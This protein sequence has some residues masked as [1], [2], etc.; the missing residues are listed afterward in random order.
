MTLILKTHHHRGRS[1]A[2]SLISFAFVAMIF[3]VDCAYSQQGASHGDTYKNPILFADYSD[4]DVIRVGNDYY[5]IASSF[6]FM[7]G[8]PILKS[9][10]L[11][12]WTIISHVFPSLD[13][14]PAYALNGGNRYGRGAWAPAIRYHDKKF[15]V[16]FPT[17]D[18]GIFMS[19]APTAEGPWT[20]PI[21]VMAQAGLE[22]PCP[23]WDDDGTAYLIHSKTGA[24][25]LYLHKM[26]ADGTK[27][28]DEGK[29]IVQNK[30]LHTLEGPKLYKR[31]DY[32]YIFAPYGG[33]STGSQVVLR[34]K[35]IYGP[36]EFRT[37]LAQGSTAVNGPH[38]GGYIET[39]SGEGWFVHF[40]SQGAY[41]RI[42]YLE[43]VKWVDDWPIMGKPI[44]D[45]T[46]EPVLTWKKPDVGGSFP[47]QR[48]QTSDEFSG[49]KLGQQWEWNHNPDDAH[50]SLSVR[51]GFMRL[52]AMPASDLLH[53]RNTLTQMMQDPA[54]DLTARIDMKG[55]KNGQQAGLAML[56]NKPSGVRV[57]DAAGKRSLV[58]FTQ[59]GDVAGPSI[60]GNL[61]QLRV[62]IDREM[63]A[64]SYS[65]DDGKSFQ[66]LGQ[67][68]RTYF[69]WW[70]AARPAIFSFNTDSNAKG[71]GAIDVDWV[72]YQPALEPGN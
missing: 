17:P 59:N 31:H 62:H 69:S 60:S 26:S 65:L 7:P 29:L 63:A 43:P 13:L 70:K 55:M 1:S 8:L 10:D 56:S 71:M 6:E 3:F 47:V 21:A 58:F 40:H 16:Y 2:V 41:G 18:E 4:P 30:D 33:V 53:A 50:W 57:I 25:P 52:T 22:D 42:D 67:S 54:F 66:P 11:V 12:N 49:R 34:S 39:P 15:F 61:L 45:T 48:P 14:G 36:Y 51:P 19:T 32:Y 68:T 38:Q 24:G 44:D 37:V 46:G 28:L 72:H 20:K 35:D 27:V 9:H 23:F 64:Y 5:L